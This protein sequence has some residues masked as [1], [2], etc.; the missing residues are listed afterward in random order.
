[1]PDTKVL[2]APTIVRNGATVSI[3]GLETSGIQNLFFAVR[4]ILVFEWQIRIFMLLG[5][6]DNFFRTCTVVTFN[7]NLSRN[8]YLRYGNLCLEK[9]LKDIPL[10]KKELIFNCKEIIRLSQSPE[11]IILNRHGRAEHF[12]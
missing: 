9:P 8:Y 5:F 6:Q 10:I 4:V 3:D 1:M 7:L 2:S 11:E 12:G